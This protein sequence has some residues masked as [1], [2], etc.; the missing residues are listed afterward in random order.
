MRRCQPVV[1]KTM[2]G[3]QHI[4]QH[5]TATH[6][7]GTA[8]RQSAI[9]VRQSNRG[10]GKKAHVENGHNRGGGGYACS[11]GWGGGGSEGKHYA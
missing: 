3:A 1:E 8:P 11:V 9:G 4:P 7:F 2:D 6:P 10:L 5:G